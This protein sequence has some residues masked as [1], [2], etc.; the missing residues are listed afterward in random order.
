MAFMAGPMNS[1]PADNRVVACVIPPRC[2][3][4]MLGDRRIRQFGDLHRDAIMA[5][6]VVVL[7]ALLPNAFHMDAIASDRAF[8]IPTP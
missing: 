1:K 4:A 6:C 8:P 2:P 5:G 3:A 7:T